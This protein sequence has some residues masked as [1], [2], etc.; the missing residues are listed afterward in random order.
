MN[1]AQINQTFITSI[2]KI[3][4]KSDVKTNQTHS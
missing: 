3:I 1:L 4:K 2:K